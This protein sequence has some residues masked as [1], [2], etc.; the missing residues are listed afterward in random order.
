MIFVSKKH[1]ILD[2]SEIAFGFPLVELSLLVEAV[3][4]NLFTTNYYSVISNSCL[5]ST[6]TTSNGL[7]HKSKLFPKPFVTSHTP[8]TQHQMK[9]FMGGS[10]IQQTFY[11]NP[12]W[13]K[14]D[15]NEYK[16]ISEGVRFGPSKGKGRLLQ[17]TLYSCNK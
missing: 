1:P 10:I 14:Q 5:P 11:H 12:S 8:C 3:S 16:Q 9:P 17:K 6:A 15:R 2:H 13:L 7:L 4:G